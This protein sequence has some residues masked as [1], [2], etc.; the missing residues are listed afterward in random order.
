MGGCY[1]DNGV[2]KGVVLIE[3]S[4]MWVVVTV[5]MVYQ[6]ELYCLKTVLC[7]WLLQ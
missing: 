7:G 4:T 2:L 6:W 5:T 3:D 1:S